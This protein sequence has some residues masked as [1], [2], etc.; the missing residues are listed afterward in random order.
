M[1]T[2]IFRQVRK[3]ERNICKFQGY[4]I[5]SAIKTG[6]KVIVV[7]SPFGLGSILM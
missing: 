5:L 6:T 1:G 4:G 7:A 3:I 2:K